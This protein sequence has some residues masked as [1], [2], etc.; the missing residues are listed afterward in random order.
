M[1][2][3]ALQTVV[4]GRDRHC[5]ECDAMFW[6]IGVLVVSGRSLFPRNGQVEAVCS[7][8][9]QACSPRENCTCRLCVCMAPM[10]LGPEVVL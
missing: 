6:R 10:L 7:A 2:G 8:M 5:E 3:E 1:Q 4:T 9:V